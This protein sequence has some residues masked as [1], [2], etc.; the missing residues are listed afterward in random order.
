MGVVYRA[1]D[2]ET[3]CDVALKTLTALAPERIYLLKREFRLLANIEH[4]NLVRLDQLFVQHR[5][6]FFAMELIDGVHLHEHV[7]RAAADDRV[8]AVQRV[9]PQLVAGLAGLHDA[10]K[11]HRDV[12]PSNIMVSAA[13]RVVYLDFGL[14]TARLPEDRLDTDSGVLAGTLAYMA[15]EQCWGAEPTPAADWYA[16][17]VVLF[18]ALTGELPFGDSDLEIVGSKTRGEPRD[19]R[20][21]RSAVPAELAQLI[22]RLL[23]RE[24][25]RR[26]T[27]DELRGLAAPRAVSTGT[28]SS[29]VA[30]RA[31]PR[32]G[33]ARTFV[34]RRAELEA[35]RRIYA[36]VS[37][38]SPA[39]VEVEGDAGVGKTECIRK[40]LAGL[41]ETSAV[42]LRGRCHPQ[43]SVQFAA[44][45]GVI[46]ALSRF[47]VAEPPERVAALLAGCGPELRRLFPVLGRVAAVAALPELEG[48]G[49]AHEIRQRGF[50]ALRALLLR[51]AVARPLVVWIDDVQWGDV[52]SAV[53]VRQLIQPQDRAPML[54]LLSFRGEDRGSTEALRMLTRP[55]T[56]ARVDREPA[57]GVAAGGTPSVRPE[58]TPR[59]RPAGM[60]TVSG[61]GA[62]R[63]VE[64][65]VLGPLAPDESRELAATLCGADPGLRAAVDTVTAEAAGSPFLLTELSRHLVARG[66]RRALDAAGALSLT[67]VVA[68]RVAE[69]SSEARRVLE[70]VSVAGRPID[71]RLALAAAGIGERGRSVVTELQHKSLLR[72]TSIE[73]EPG[74]ET[75]HDRWREMV[76]ERI[77][78]DARRSRHLAIA[79]AL[80]TRADADPAAVFEHYLGG[81]RRD[82]ARGWALRAADAAAGALAFERAA[83]LY[84]A[85]IDLDPADATT[86][87]LYVKRADALANA[88]RGGDAAASFEEAARRAAGDGSSA[89]RIL[90]LQRRAADQYLRS[91]HLAKGRT[92]LAAVLRQLGVPFPSGR[93]AALGSSIVQRLRFIARGHRVRSRPIAPDARLRLDTCWTAATSLSVVDPLIADGIGVRCLVDAL[94]WGDRSHV[95]RG[96]GLEAAREA[97]LGGRFFERRSRTLLAALAELAAR[98]D[99]PYDHAWR[100]Q[101]VGTTA[102]FGG[103]WKRAF[104]EC[105]AAAAM[106]RSRCRGAAWEVV[107]GES[108]ALT[109][110]VHLGRFRDL[111][112]RLPAAIADADGRDDVYA[113]TSLRMGL[114]NMLWLAADR[115]DEA[116]RNAD[117][118]IARWPPETFLVQHYLHL[119]AAVQ[120]ELYAG[121]GA[122]AWELVT[123]AWPAVRR[124]RLLNI[125]VARVDLRF[126]RGR[127]ALAA[128]HELDR[129]S[130]S[131]SASRPPPAA[132]TPA[133]ARRARLRRVV[134]DEVGLLRREAFPSAAPLAHM[135]DGALRV[136]DGE[137]E[138]AAERFA[139]AGRAFRA[140]D[141]AGCAA[142]AAF[143][144]ARLRGDVEAAAAAESGL[145][146][147]GVVVPAALA[148]ML[149]GVP[150]VAS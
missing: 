26:P 111:A 145:R 132:V 127:A 86:S 104:E 82:V 65:I 41:D 133:H 19:V 35:F 38:G 106:W 150:S 66:G 6:C 137:R 16:L 54:L 108:F 138:T 18:E 52:D 56:H 27:G 30:D 43:E 121:R 7:R 78:P 103:A 95:V 34:G 77:P 53:M 24:P 46:D 109:A 31:R 71:R 23:E 48:E 120:A 134:N 62:A 144:A 25:E 88:G 97:S 90:T 114:P 99:D 85:A 3:G 22:A 101:S 63:V 13:G 44:L 92:L 141:M 11:L 140:V 83:A 146:S 61:D 107:T 148:A 102:F 42:V 149:S 57:D 122:R 130:C 70:I 126:L 147:E 36:R 91:G 129:G 81:G 51:I 9:L 49:D 75:Y 112:E 67:A 100:H 40:F 139:H 32:L 74:I 76:L 124:S 135:L 15:P 68:E 33:D 94:R 60:P 117:G 69:L 110:L 4:P 21:L 119:V 5:H 47:L 89:A 12:K 17:G 80:A 143:T 2:R 93:R 98:S 118:A 105:D 131:G 58:G 73:D 142:V 123:G 136:L 29:P 79:E 116:R 72:A 37:T 10:G 64:R 125:A 84:R 55:E 115:P 8:R 45:D 87:E 1:H 20:E 128:A 39:V 14:A 50:A 59:V 113:A 96:L 28:P